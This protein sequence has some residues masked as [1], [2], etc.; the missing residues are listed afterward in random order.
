MQ[1]PINSTR[2]D[3]ITVPYVDQEESIANEN[4]RTS[5]DAHSVQETQKHDKWHGWFGAFQ[6]IF[7][8]YLATHIVFFL[9]TYLVNLF[10]LGD[11]SKQ[12]LK[13]QDTLEYWDHWDTGQFVAIAQGG[14][15]ALW[16][17]AFFPLYPM[18]EAVLTPILH[19]PYYAGLLLSNLATLG[20]FTVLYRLV[21]EEFDAER[22]EC[23]GTIPCGIPNS[24]LSLSSIQRIA[25]SLARSIQ[26]LLHTAWELVVSRYGRVTCKLDTFC[27]CFTAHSFLL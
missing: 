24:L 22:A 13:I 19:K 15:D 25:F 4:I 23:T 11:F 2:K 16:R 8:I 12:A 6:R 21:D 27:W 5:Q 10:F 20:L 17:T 3:V 7:P 18:L 9:L 14:Y 1:S 26:F